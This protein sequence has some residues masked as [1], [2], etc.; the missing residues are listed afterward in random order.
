MGEPAFNM[1]VLEVIDE[2]ELYF[3]APGFMPSVSTIAP[4]GSERFFEEM[5][6]IKNAKFNKGNFQLQFSIHTTDEKKRN[7]L[8]PVKK[9]SFAKMGK[10]GE[11]FHT[12]PDRKITLS[13][14]PSD[15]YPVEPEKIYVFFDPEHFMIKLT[16][17]N[18]TSSSAK[19]NLTSV[20]DP[21]SG[22]NHQS[23]K[24]KFRSMG[25]DVI[26]SIGE[27]EENR[28]GSTCGQNISSVYES[29]K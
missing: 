17:L 12:S 25:Y 6:S 8:I 4:N 14:A 7:E 27:F 3:N 1:N 26:V 19:N 11:R 28:I 16:P 21:E 9:W 20:I 24:D 18:T 2:F 23:L 5:L 29:K 10:Y 22:D 13:F 15:K